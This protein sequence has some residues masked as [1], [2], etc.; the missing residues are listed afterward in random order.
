MIADAKSE[1]IGGLFLLLGAGSM[2]FIIAEYLMITSA[3]PTDIAARLVYYEDNFVALSRG[4]HFEVLAMALIGAGALVRLKTTG[5]AGWALAAIGVAAVLPMYPLMI[6][7]Y[8]SAFA[9]GEIGANSFGLING[10]TTELFFVG[11]LLTSA[12]LSLAFWLERSSG[13]SPVPRWVVI[14]AAV[15]NGL[16]ALGFAALHAGL[17]IPLPLV[18]PVGLLG[19]I[20]VAVFGAFVAFRKR[21]A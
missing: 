5:R 6:G 8:S 4:W 11:N 20:S 13:P 16:A 3:A 18:G 15:S 21:A 7:G 12:G 17:G 10:I 14:I 1:H 19:F 2:P 9:G